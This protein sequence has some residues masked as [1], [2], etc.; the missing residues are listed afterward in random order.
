MIKENNLFARVMRR[1]E[2]HSGD[3]MSLYILKNVD[4]SSENINMLGVAVSKKFSKSS[5]KRN[6]VKRL[7]KE[8]YRLNENNIETG[9][10]MV[11]LWKNNV[12][13]SNV[14]FNNIKNDFDK[15]MSKA[16][17]FVNKEQSL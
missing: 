17:L 16:N 8:V 11:F 3:L 13:Y 9:Y 14:T 5:V 1:G 12:D 7:I 4:N 15:C 2:W 10:F 6:R